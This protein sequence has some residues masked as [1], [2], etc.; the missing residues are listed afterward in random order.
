M[1]AGGG[2][3]AA[4]REKKDRGEAM[5]ALTAGAPVV[6]RRLFDDGRFD[7]FVEI[8]PIFNF[9][10]DTDFDFSGGVGARFYF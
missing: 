7:V 5:K 8:A 10:P 2:D 3:L 4:L 1:R 9:V 6:T